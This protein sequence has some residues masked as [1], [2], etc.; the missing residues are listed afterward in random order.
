MYYLPDRAP[1]AMVSADF[2]AIKKRERKKYMSDLT[3][4]KSKSKGLWFQSNKR[5]NNFFFL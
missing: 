1:A 2:Q 4:A 3:K 5:L